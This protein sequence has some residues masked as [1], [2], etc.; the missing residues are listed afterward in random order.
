MKR[1]GVEGVVMAVELASGVV[2]VLRVMLVPGVVPGIDIV[3]AVE[4][5]T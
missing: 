2:L 1:F 4:L 5:G 3:P